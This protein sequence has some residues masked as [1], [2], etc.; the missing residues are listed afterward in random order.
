MPRYQKNTLRE[1]QEYSTLGT[2]KQ[3]PQELLSLHDLALFLKR[4]LAPKSC[5]KV[6]PGAP[7]P[8]SRT[9]GPGRPGPGPWGCIILGATRGIIFQKEMKNL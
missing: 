1:T 8:P 2:K 4:H 9:G 6:G 7:T 3:L 5:S